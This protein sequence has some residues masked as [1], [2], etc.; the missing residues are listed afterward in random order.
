M[1]I[2]NHWNLITSIPGYPMILF[3]FSTYSLDFGH[4]VQFPCVEIYFLNFE[5][6]V[7]ENVKT[8]NDG[9]LAQK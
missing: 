4:L 3:L 6:S 1:V 7:C 8:F 2:L 9:T 5:D